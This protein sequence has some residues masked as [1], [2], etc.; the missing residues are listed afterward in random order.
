VRFL[1]DNEHT[2][3]HHNTVKMYHGKVQQKKVW[4][5]MRT[6]MVSAPPVTVSVTSNR[7]Q[8]RLDILS[9]KGFHVDDQVVV[10]NPFKAYTFCDGKTGVI[11]KIVK[12]GHVHF[13]VEMSDSK[14]NKLVSMTPNHMYYAGQKQNWVNLKLSQID[15]QALNTTGAAGSVLGKRPHQ[16]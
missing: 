15:K 8:Q 12:E 1:Y 9:Y 6:Q 16:P 14:I 3:M 5:K 13:F 4:Q 10:V 7:N 2:A 11:K